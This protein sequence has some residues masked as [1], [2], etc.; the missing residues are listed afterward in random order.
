[1]QSG[2]QSISFYTLGGPRSE[3]E[4]QST[5]SMNYWI[6]TYRDRFLLWN[7]TSVLLYCSTFKHHQIALTQCCMKYFHGVNI[8][9]F[10]TRARCLEQTGGRTKRLGLFQHPHAHRLCQERRDSWLGI[11]S[12]LPWGRSK[13]QTWIV[14]YIKGNHAGWSG[15]GCTGSTCKG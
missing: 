15:A 14:D 2:L 3:N 12:M 4:A 11:A 9:I 10:I 1:M 6:L 7:T 5:E 13:E 8:Q